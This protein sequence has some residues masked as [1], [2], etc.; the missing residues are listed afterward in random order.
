MPRRQNKPIPN[1]K[2]IQKKKLTP[3]KRARQNEAIYSRTQQGMPRAL[4]VPDKNTNAAAAKTPPRCFTPP[5]PEM[6]PQDCMS[7]IKVG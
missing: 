3:P 7:Q 6:H 1:R 4:A 2:S 5:Q